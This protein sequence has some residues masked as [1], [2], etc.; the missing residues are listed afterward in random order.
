MKSGYRAFFDTNILVYLHDEG[1]P[2]KRSIAKELVSM[3][4][5][6]GK[7]VVSTQVY[8]ELYVVLTKKLR[9]PLSSHIALEEL[10]KLN[11][12]V[13]TVVIIPPLIFEAITIQ[14]E[15]KISF[16]DA[17]IVSAAIYGRCKV[18]FTEDLNHG[19][20]IKGVKIENPFLD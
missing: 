15:N 13:R 20:I 8:Q 3:W 7:M 17:L 2:E 4:F 14:K 1:S 9:P 5:P 19:Q 6:T 16:W 12:G 11:L 10:K 18:I